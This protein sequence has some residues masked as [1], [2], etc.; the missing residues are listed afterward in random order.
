[1]IGVDITI[2]MIMSQLSGHCDVISNRLW[3]HQQNGNW[4]CGTWE[5]VWRFKFLS[6]FMD[7]L[8]HAKNN[9]MYVLPW[10]TNSALP[11]VLFWCLFPLLLRNLRNKHQNN[12]LLSTKTGHD[13]SLY[14]ILYLLH[15]TIW[16]SIVYT[17]LLVTVVPVVVHW[18]CSLEF[19]MLWAMALHGM[20]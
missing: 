7:L 11:R 1:M 2:H 20:A 16:Y 12:P 9:V 13:L 8:C 18:C 4:A 3:S 15:Y 19:Y 5:D 10:W 6:S 17:Y 14:V